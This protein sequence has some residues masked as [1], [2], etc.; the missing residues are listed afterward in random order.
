MEKYHELDLAAHKSKELV[1]EENRRLNKALKK[2]YPKW[3]R[4]MDILLACVILMNFGAVFMTNFVVER[5]ADII[6]QTKDPEYKV[7]LKEVNPIQAEMHGYEQAPNGSS[8]MLALGIAASMWLL[9]LFGYV[10]KREHVI[11]K[12]GL[13]IMM[14]LLIFYFSFLG[15][16]FFSDL[17]FFIGK[18]AYS[19]F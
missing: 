15:W 11:T 6:R 12:Q 3:F 18:V 16:D 7:I 5:D 9:I 10:W 8:M 4:T 19:G 14:T 13:I 2:E 17:G 1:K